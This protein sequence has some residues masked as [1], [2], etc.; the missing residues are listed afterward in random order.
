MA[1]KSS[2]PRRSASI[3]SEMPILRTTKA[4]ETPNNCSL[5]L[6]NTVA[7]APASLPVV[8]GGGGT[9]RPQNAHI[10]LLR[11][12]RDGAGKP[13]SMKGAFAGRSLRDRCCDFS[14]VRGRSKTA[15]TV[16]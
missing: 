1:L 5:G 7:I 4:V 13:G 3:K 12:N 14:A 16:G 8:A 6:A 15:F 11:E 2:Q 10:R 9:E